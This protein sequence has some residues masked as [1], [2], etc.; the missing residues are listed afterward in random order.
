[1]ETISIVALVVSVI[2]LGLSGYLTYR[3]LRLSRQ[4]N[5]LPVLVDM[6]REHRNRDLREARHFIFNHLDEYDVTGG[7]DG[8][9][10]DKQ[11]L[12]SDLAFFYDNLG[13]LVAYGIVDPEPVAGYLGGSVIL[14][15]DKLRPL[16]SAE[17]ARRQ[18]LSDPKRWQIYFEY[19]YQTVKAHNP[20][21][22][23]NKLHNWNLP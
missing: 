18:K 6:F 13:A 16:I 22:D 19:L 17:R 8:L 23:R 3:Q 5:S 20:E 11:L 2:A 15:F 12:V 10:R 9:P 14:V 1:M 4:A 21:R 7:L